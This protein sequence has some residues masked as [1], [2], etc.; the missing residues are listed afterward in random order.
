MEDHPSAPAG[1]TS[2]PVR[3]TNGSAWTASGK[4]RKLDVAADS[5]SGANGTSQAKGDRRFGNSRSVNELF[6]TGVGQ[7][8]EGA[9]GRLWVCDVSQTCI[10]GSVV[11]E[12]TQKLCFKYMRSRPAWD[13]HSVR[14][15]WFQGRSAADDNQ[16]SCSQLQPPGRRV[17]QKGSYSIYEVDGAEATV[18]ALYMPRSA[19]LICPAVL[20]EPQSVRQAVHRPQSEQRSF[21]PITC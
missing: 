14:D 18:S 11:R 20:S 9:R 4:K 15:V 10:V 16:S 1:S 17:Y 21:M 5:P 8:G 13:R 19:R 2:T 3:A 12:L 6:A 7:S